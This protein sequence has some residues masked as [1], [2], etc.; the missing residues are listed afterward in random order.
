MRTDDIIKDLEAAID[1]KC[2]CIAS[3]IWVSVMF[4]GYKINLKIDTECSIE[5]VRAAMESLDNEK[6]TIIEHS[7]PI[8][9]EGFFVVYI[10]Y[11]YEKDVI[12]SIFEGAA[13]G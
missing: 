3:K 10:N 12:A 2:K 1:C 11:T 7:I 8:T 13:C 4:D 9:E 6:Y 5:E